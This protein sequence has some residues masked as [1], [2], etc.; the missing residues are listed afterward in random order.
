MP[1]KS[2]CVCVRV[3]VHVCLH[4]CVCVC[5]CIC[6]CACVGGECT[7]TSKGN[8][9]YTRT[10]LTRTKKEFRLLLHVRPHE[11]SPMGPGIWRGLWSPF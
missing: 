4:M 2:V 5:V 1:P 8:V 11:I 3:R 7:L 10:E 6:A 9:A